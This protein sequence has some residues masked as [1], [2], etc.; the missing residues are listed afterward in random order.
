[1]IDA[2]LQYLQDCYSHSWCRGGAQPFLRLSHDGE[3]GL[4]GEQKMRAHSRGSCA[5]DL[6]PSRIGSCPGGDA[7]VL[8][9]LQLLPM[10]FILSKK[11][12]M[13]QVIPC[14]L[15]QMLGQA[16]QE[17]RKIVLLLLRACKLSCSATLLKVW[18]CRCLSLEAFRGMTMFL[19]YTQWFVHVVMVCIDGDAVCSVP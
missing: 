12:K 5:C 10:A 7:P 2:S 4:R 17:N 14:L 9:Q 6:G 15:P 18:K 1:M 11:S 3:S 19:Q 13:P 16:R 8:P